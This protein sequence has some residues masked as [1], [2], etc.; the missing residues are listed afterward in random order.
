VE[1][2]NLYLPHQSSLILTTQPCKQTLPSTDS[3]TV[4]YVS[5]CLII[6]I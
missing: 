6:N 5:E 1:H 2:E 3:D 4:L